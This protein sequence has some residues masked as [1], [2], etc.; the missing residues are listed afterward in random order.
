MSNECKDIAAP[1]GNKWSGV[2]EGVETLPR[3]LHVNC[4]KTQVEAREADNVTENG[5]RVNVLL[6]PKKKMNDGGD[7]QEENGNGYGEHVNCA[8]NL[9][10]TQKNW[11][12]K[13]GKI[14]WLE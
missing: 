7:H 12:V 6:F 10:K 9:G 11:R 13:I 1:F 5:P 2:L 8:I 4:Q 14:F 3:F